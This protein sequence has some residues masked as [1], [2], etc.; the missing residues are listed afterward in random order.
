MVQS[1]KTRFNGNSQEVVAYARIWGKFKAMDRYEVRDYLA[2]DKF[3]EEVGGDNRIGD[4]PA[5][6]TDIHWAENLVDAFTKKV[7]SL[8]AEKQHLHEQ[9][10]RMK[11][12]LDY[13][14][15]Q[16]GLTIQPKVG[17]LLSLCK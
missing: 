2:F 4:N 1:L 17:H 8:E 16:E 7:L 15:S 12:E 3:L 14:K 6:G 9:L 5:L 10:N 13:Y 11:V